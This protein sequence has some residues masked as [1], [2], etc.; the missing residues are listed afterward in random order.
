M[1]TENSEIN[2]PHKLILNLLQKL[3]LKSTDNHVALQN[4]S[5]YYM[6]KNVKKK[7]QYKGNKLKII[8]PTWNDVFELPDGFY[9]VKDTQD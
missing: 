9:S 3:D 8:A 6:W 5:V 4:L 2:E 1:N 7:K